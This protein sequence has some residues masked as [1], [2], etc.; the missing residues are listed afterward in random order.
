[1]PIGAIAGATAV[2]GVGSAVI[3][4]KAQTKAANQAAA[5]QAQTTAANNALAR[6]FYAS[7]SAN[8]EPF[9]AS[10]VGALRNYNAL[11]GLGGDSAGALSAFNTFRDSTGYQFQF[12]EGMRALNSGWAAKGAL[13]SGAAMKSFGQYGQ[14][15]AKGALGQYMDRLAA[16]ANTGMGAASALAGVGQNLVSNVSNNNQASGSALANAQLANGAASANMWGNV[17]QSVGSALGMYASSYAPMSRNPY[18]IA[19]G[20]IY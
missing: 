2:A 1:M 4:S 9:R 5:T 20:G 10:G 19:A 13:N 7:N 15:L 8:L 16:Q 17:G 3:G 11:L 6:E 12:D 18:G 14:N